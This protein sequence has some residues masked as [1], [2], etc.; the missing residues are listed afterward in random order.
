MV[1]ER[2]TNPRLPIRIDWERQNTWQLALQGLQS[3]LLASIVE[4]AAWYC[5]R[6]EKEALC[7]ASKQ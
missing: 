5:C 1:A 4:F 3:A 6:G 7:L 2:L